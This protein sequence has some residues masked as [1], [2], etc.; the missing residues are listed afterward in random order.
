MKIIISE[1][2]YK[3]LKEQL[4]GLL[5]MPETGQE[6]TG[7]LGQKDAGYTIKYSDSE[8]VKNLFDLARTWSSSPQ[9]WKNITSIAQQM[10]KQL[11]GIGS[12]SFLTELSKIKTTQQLA[13][14]IK[15]WSY[16]GQNLYTWISSEYGIGW[17]QIISTLRKN[18]G[19]YIKDTY[20]RK[21]T[22]SA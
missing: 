4:G 14:L 6:V 9:D 19:N 18:F 1:Q 16:N 8:K 12:G 10:H 17:D 15:N 21:E 13:A 22:Y 2:Q 5:N 11:S 3:A 20:A 7:S